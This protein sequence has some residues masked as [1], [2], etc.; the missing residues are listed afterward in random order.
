MKAY[1]R[2]LFTKVRRVR[3][4]LGKVTGFTEASLTFGA[5]DT[6]VSGANRA[7]FEHLLSLF[8]DL[9]KEALFIGFKVYWIAAFGGH[10]R[11]DYSICPSFLYKF[12]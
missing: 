3:A 9:G 6:A 8:Y 10:F 2:F 4:N 7:G 1:E 11:K 12:L 5:V